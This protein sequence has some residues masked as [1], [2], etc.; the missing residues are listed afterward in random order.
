MLHNVPLSIKLRT[1]AFGSFAAQQY[2]ITGMA[3]SGRQER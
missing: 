1:S 3:A 2:L